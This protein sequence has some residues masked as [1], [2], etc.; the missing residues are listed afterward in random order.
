[1]TLIQRS[2]RFHEHW[3]QCLDKNGDGL[4]I[5]FPVKVHLILSWSPKISYAKDGVLDI[6]PRMPLKKMSLDFVQ[7]PYSVLNK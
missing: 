4:K 5:Q 7:K 2:C 3:D 1:M 6:A